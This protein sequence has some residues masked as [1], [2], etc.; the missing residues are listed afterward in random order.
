RIRVM[1]DA[2]GVGAGV[3]TEYN[4]ITLDEKVTD[5]PPFVAWNAGAGVLDPFARTIKNDP[6]SLMNKDFYANLKAQAWWNLYMRFY[7]TWKCID[8]IE[9]GQ[10]VPNYDAE[11]L[12]S[13]DSNMPMLQ[14]LMKEL[15]QPTR[16]ESA[17]LRA[18]VNKTPDGMKS[19]NLADAVVMCFFPV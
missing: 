12:I 14:Q 8:A 9:N 7:K 11:E 16:G 19:P 10:P 2:I 1:Y 13:L 15:A 17:G 18:I 4:R 6:D 5:L 3:K